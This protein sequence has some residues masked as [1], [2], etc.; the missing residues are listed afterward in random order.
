MLTQFLSQYMLLAR[1]ASSSS[2]LRSS[3]MLQSNIGSGMH[4]LH[5]LLYL[6][7]IQTPS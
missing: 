5:K 3:S 7:L 1:L 2:L 4:T 6:Y